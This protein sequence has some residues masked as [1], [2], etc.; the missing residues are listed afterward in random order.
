MSTASSGCSDCDNN[1]STTEVEDSGCCGA[2]AA[3]VTTPTESVNT[4][5]VRLGEV[6]DTEAGVRVVSEDAL[7]TGVIGSVAEA[8]SDVTA[9][10]EGSVEVTVVDLVNKVRGALSDIHH[11]IHHHVHLSHMDMSDRLYPETTA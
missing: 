11:R 3:A 1:I 5:D 2:R 10:M 8:V 7:A 6:R 9:A 4:I